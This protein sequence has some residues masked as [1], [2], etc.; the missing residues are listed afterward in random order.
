EH[1]DP[2][3]MNPARS[4]VPGPGGRPARCRERGV[5]AAGALPVEVSASALAGTELV[6]RLRIE[7]PATDDRVPDGIALANVREHVAFDHGEVGE[8]AGLDRSQVAVEAEVLGPV[9]RGTA[10]RLV[11]R[12]AALYEHPELPVG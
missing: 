1:G 8:L 5:S 11:R 3:S 12:H 9:Q 2:W 4:L 6:H 10:Q 7:D